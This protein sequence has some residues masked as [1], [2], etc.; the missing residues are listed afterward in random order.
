MTISTITNNTVG[1]WCEM[2]NRYVKSVIYKHACL[3]ST[4]QYAVNRS[5]PMPQNLLAKIKNNNNN[6]NKLN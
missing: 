1:L 5:H 2:P 4:D 6:N 3:I